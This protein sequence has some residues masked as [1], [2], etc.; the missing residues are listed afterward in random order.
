MMVVLGAIASLSPV[1]LVKL[2]ERTGIDKKSLT[3]VIDRAREQAGV[4]ITKN[5]PTYQID[6][7][8]PILKEEG[9]IMWWQEF[10]A[11]TV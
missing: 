9:A 2:A 7:W 3:R 10:D 8:G 1:T 5:G 6:D 11:P 4:V